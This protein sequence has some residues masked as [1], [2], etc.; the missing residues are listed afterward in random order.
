MKLALS[1]STLFVFKVVFSF[2]FKKN[3]DVDANEGN[4]S[5]SV[6]KPLSSFW[7]PI[8]SKLI[9]EL[10]GEF[11]FGLSGLWL[12]DLRILGDDFVSFMGS[13]MGME[14]FLFSTAVWSFM[15]SVTNTDGVL[16]TFWF[17]RLRP[18]S[19]RIRYKLKQN[20]Y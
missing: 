14:S 17:N 16:A 15:S 7:V 11:L 5:K 10:P 12:R 19:I 1:F 3:V 2:E 9:S 8:F 13:S 18:Y 6:A 20:E 4:F